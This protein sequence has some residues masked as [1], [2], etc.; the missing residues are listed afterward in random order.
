M[1]AAGGT[2]ILNVDSGATVTGDSAI[3]GA[4]AGGSGT[5]TVSGTGST[6]TNDGVLEVG[7]AG[8]GE[9]TIE[10][11]G[12]VS[13]TGGVIGR[14][15]DS[16]GTVTVTGAD[17]TWNNSASLYVGGGQSNAGG[18]GTLNILPG[19]TVHVE[20]TLTI[21]DDGTVNVHGGTLE[22]AQL[23]MP[24]SEFNFVSGT[25]NYTTDKTIDDDGLIVNEVL[26]GEA[27]V[28]DGQ[29]LSIEQTAT[30]LTGL[31]LGGGTFSAGEANN[32]NLLEFDHGHLNLT[33]TDVTVGFEGVF[34]STVAMDTGQHLHVSQQVDVN[35]K[36]VVTIDHNASFGAST[37][38]NSGEIVLAG[39]L[40][41]LTG[42]VA[43]NTGLIH[44]HGRVEASLSNQA[45][46]G[47][48]VEAD[49]RL[50]FTGQNNSSAGEINLF[51]GRIELV[52]GLAHE[53]RLT[54]LE[55]D[56]RVHG[57]I[58]NTGD[59]RV[60]D[61]TTGRFI[62]D[63][64]NNGEF[65]VSDS[66]RAV[67]TGDVSGDG[68]FPGPGE[69]E[70]AGSLSPGNSPGSMA[71]GGDVILDDADVRMELAGTTA[72]QEH[73]HVHVAGLLDVSGSLDVTLLDG[74]QPQAGDTF[75]LLDFGQIV[76]AFTR[77]NLPDLG[78]HLAWD[79][80]QLYTTGDLSVVAEHLLGDMNL[81]G[82]VDTGDVAAL[83]LALTDPATYMAEYG[84]DEATMT[85]LGDINQDGVF[86]TGDVAP[87][88]QLL[89]GGGPPSVPEPGSLALL[90]LGALAS[91]RRGRA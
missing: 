57:D 39:A 26:D 14:D 49:Q 21:W 82:V 8:T 63:L 36:G 2:G 77:I 84:V 13:S 15:S 38:H 43:H 85:A 46:G 76:G 75:H 78:T 88:V 89:V 73:D 62:G 11:G 51:G 12:S 37:L 17:S 6:W 31:Q 80:Q 67:I 24:G 32:L 41:R 61:K 9:L 83:V 64:V 54:I 19:A 81:D 10:E 3:I 42:D 50:V 16:H 91:L 45:D 22:M 1:S 48:R 30:L 59:I 79:D 44:G 72:G 35:P 66:S 70:V 34:G 65:Y 74:F 47:V 28:G 20:E 25:V 55:Q 58:D 33:A 52:A 90:G 4:V 23:Q 29:H 40:A 27:V 69:I 5:A 56:S 53:G 18:H 60:Q 71:F 87:F 86:D 7:G 68:D